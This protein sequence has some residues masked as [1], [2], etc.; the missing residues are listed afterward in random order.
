MPLKPLGVKKMKVISFAHAKKRILDKQHEE[1]ETKTSFKLKCL[2]NAELFD[3]YKFYRHT[4]EDTSLD[5][6]GKVDTESLI[7]LCE[8]ALEVAARGLLEDFD[9]RFNFV[10]TEPEK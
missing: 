1:C 5:C 7:Y 10:I 4:L 8:V 6:G 9:K 3:E 2:T